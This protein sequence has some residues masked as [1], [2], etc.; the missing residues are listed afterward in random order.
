MYEEHV[1]PIDRDAGEFSS[2]DEVPC[3]ILV[4]LSTLQKSRNQTAT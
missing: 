3:I 2:D 4:L 1:A